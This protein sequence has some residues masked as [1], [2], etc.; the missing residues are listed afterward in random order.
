MAAASNDCISTYAGVYF[1][2]APTEQKPLD[3]W[4]LGGL[5]RAVSVIALIMAYINFVNGFTFTQNVEPLISQ[6]TSCRQLE[7]RW[8]ITIDRH[9]ISA[10]A[11]MI[12]VHSLMRLPLNMARAG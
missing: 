9:C 12:L 1:K 7:P 11:G 2:K 5:R 3:G 8:L 10:T 4:R 6:C